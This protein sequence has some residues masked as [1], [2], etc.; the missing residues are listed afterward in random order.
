[1]Q[2]LRTILYI[3]LTIIIGLALINVVFHIAI[4]GVILA[5]VVALGFAGYF[6]STICRR[7]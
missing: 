6:L 5:M 3:V 7:K 4:A 2:K 1:M